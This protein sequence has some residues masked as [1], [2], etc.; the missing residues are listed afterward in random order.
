MGCYFFVLPEQTPAWNLKPLSGNEEVS[1][2][3]ESILASYGY[4]VSEMDVQ[5]GMISDYGELRNYVQTHGRKD[6]NQRLQNSDR[7]NPPFFYWMVDNSSKSSTRS[8]AVPLTLDNSFRLYFS[9]DGQVIRFTPSDGRKVEGLNTSLIESVFAGD[10][11]VH[12]SLEYISRIEAGVLRVLFDPKAD[13][14]T[15]I[16]GETLVLNRKDVQR[17]G[18][19][20]IEKSYWGKFNFTQAQLTATGMVE[21]TMGENASFVFSTADTIDGYTYEITLDMSAGGY[22]TDLNY[23]YSLVDTHEKANEELLMIYL[24]GGSVIII[25]IVLVLFL[26]RLNK[27]LLDP[28]VVLPD[29]IILGI[30]VFGFITSNILNTVPFELQITTFLAGGGILAGSAIVA[31]LY[32][33]FAATTESLSHES[34]PDKMQTLTLLRNGFVFN[35]RAGRSLADGISAGFIFLILATAVLLLDDHAMFEPGNNGPPSISTLDILA[36]STLVFESLLNSMYYVFL[37]IAP[38]SFFISDKIRN[39]YL[40]FFAVFPATLLVSGLMPEASSGT[41]DLAYGLVTAGMITFIFFRFDI[42]TMLTAL[43]T[44]TLLVKSQDM[45]FSPVSNI[46]SS[47][48]IFSSLAVLAGIAVIGMGRKLDEYEMPDFM[49]Q[50]LRRLAHQERMQREHELA[51]QVHQSFLPQSLPDYPQ[52]D[53]AAVCK[54]ALNVGGDYYDFFSLSGNRLAVVIGDV[55]G[56]GIHAA[57]YMTLV[58]GYLQSLSNDGTSPA[59]VVT[60]AHSLFRKSAAKGTFITLIYGIIDLN[61]NTFTF[62]RAG[63]NPLI[64]LK[65]D[66]EFIPYKPNGYAVGMADAQKFCSYL[67]E[68]TI[69]F[70]P[71]DSLVLFTDGYPECISQKNFRLGDEAFLDIINTNRNGSAGSMAKNINSEVQQFGKNANQHDDMT[72]IVIRRSL[73]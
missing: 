27:Q 53:I 48:L 19:H 28:R 14:E 66:T 49:P 44:G 64:H 24:T 62:V 70:P 10:E 51:R 17:M 12:P 1:A 30:L 18:K 41:A 29:A 3:S 59:Q 36:G 35:R 26:I 42:L 33:L 73:P 2:S 11:P 50:Y 63:H 43:F 68:Q 52:L 32:L 20:I 61:E 23:S 72:M 46:S 39:R 7:L 37:V 22:P 25:F 6:L 69:A 40:R 13:S 60:K 9:V 55:S 57:F 34:H 58:K 54:P 45:I 38:F 47:V 8:A 21:N 31:L 67:D 16:D 65:G 5:S 56:K 4:T 15:H 71:G